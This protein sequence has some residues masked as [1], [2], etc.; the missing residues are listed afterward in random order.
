VGRERNSSQ[1]GPVFNSRKSFHGPNFNFNFELRPAR[2]FRTP[3]T[4]PKSFGDY[5]PGTIKT[6]ITNLSFQENFRDFNHTKWAIEWPEFKKF[7]F[8]EF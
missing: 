1:C 2:S 6:L 5:D 8:S 4:Q 3:A 7:I